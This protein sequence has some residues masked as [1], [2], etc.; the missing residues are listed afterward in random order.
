M[1]E[2]YAAAYNKEMQLKRAVKKANSDDE[3]RQALNDLLDYYE[4]KGQDEKVQD[5]KRQIAE[6][7]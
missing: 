7:D 4:G 6:L 5:V 1:N 3:K 2:R